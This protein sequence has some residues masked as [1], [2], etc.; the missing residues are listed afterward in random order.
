MKAPDFWQKNSFL[1]YLLLPLGWVYGRLGAW[2]W[3]VTEPME[4]P[5]P[6]ICIGNLVAGGAGKTP[7]AMALG[8]ILHARRLPFHYLSRG[9]GGAGL[10]TPQC[11]TPRHDAA[12]VGD[13]PVLLST[14]APCWVCRDRKL[15]ANA[16][17]R[18]GAHLLVMDDGYQNPSMHKSLNILVIDG[19]YGIGNGALIPAGPLRESWENGIHRAD[20]V[21]FVGKDLHGLRHRIPPEVPQF[22]GFM[23]PQTPL[24]DLTQPALPFAGIGRPEKFFTM[25]RDAGVKLAAT[26]PFPDHHRYTEADLQQLRQ[27][28]AT[29]KATLTCTTKDAVKLPPHFRDEIQV[30][31]VR[32][33]FEDLRSFTEWLEPH[34]L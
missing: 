21:I 8:E 27:R 33:R 6:V 17:L 31:H 7:V 26:A 24:R 16:A 3:Q 15:A 11:V 29:L 13:E 10:E 32:F 28:A 20:A 14:V 18:A 9:Y 25:L 23:E 2:R 12:T 19:S 5:I 1:K 34:L 4:L 22:T 30:V